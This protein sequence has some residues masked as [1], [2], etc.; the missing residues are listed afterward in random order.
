MAIVFN[1]P[2]C[3]HPYRLKD[4]LAGKKAT[5]KNP[6]CRQVIT[7]PA[8]PPRPEDVEAA[9]LSHLADAPAAAAAADAPI[10]VVCSFCDHKWTE[11]RD[12]AG[13][14]VLCPNPECRQRNKVPVPKDDKPANWRETAQGPSLA[15]ENFEKPK[16]VM[17]A[18]ARM[19]GREAWQKGGGADA[20]YEPVP[21]KRKVFLAA[22]VVVPLAGLV[23]GGVW[24]YTA[25][26]N[27]GEDRSFESALQQL[28]VADLPAGDGPLYSAVMQT[29]AGEYE[30]RAPRAPEQAL[31]KAFDHFTR[32]RN[33]IQQAAQ[34]EDTKKGGM[35]KYAVAAELAIAQLGLGGTEAEVK[36]QAR[37]RWVPDQGG[38][39]ILRVNEKAVTVR[40][41]LQ[42]TLQVMLPADFDFRAALARRLVRELLKRGRADIAADL[43]EM[44]FTGPELPEAEAVVALEVYR[45]DKA[46]PFPAQAAEALKATL[47][48][49]AAG[50][51][52]VPASAAVLWKAVGTDKAPPVVNLQLP[53]GGNVSPGTRLAVVG[54]LLLDGRTEEALEAVRR[55]G[56]LV[57]QLR[58]AVLVAECAAEPGPVFDVAQGL[59]AKAVD[60]KKKAE[61]STAPPSLLFRLAQRAGETGKVEAAKGLADLIADDGLKAWA[62]ADALRL[63]ATTGARLDEAAFEVPADPAKLRVGH[64]WGRYWVARHN[65]KLSGDRGAETKAAKGWPSGTVAPLGLAGVA[66]GM[67]ER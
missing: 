31:K 47:A 54:T 10:P 6:N 35:A 26:S 64:A 53:A 4:E 41:E 12:K 55:P 24:A 42:R 15:K 13:K 27:R 44:L 57:G 16:D 20:D 11:P 65:A 60:P 32:A 67:R 28:S 45:A 50:K 40:T 59:A 38:G 30:L 61:G 5:C 8:A 23:Y 46:S 34:K 9:A 29:V 14:N 2:H 51:D 37:Y 18:E 63:A 66:L 3:A 21:L 19:V 48:K 1:C 58:A 62:R 17:D 56:E 52:P 7:V 36:A 25:W 49:G 22:L 43:P 33:D 39:R